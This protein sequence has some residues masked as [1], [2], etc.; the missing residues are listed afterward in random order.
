MESSSNAF[1]A[2][3]LNNFQGE[4]GCKKKKKKKEEEE[5]STSRI[6]NY[7]TLPLRHQPSAAQLSRRRRRRKR[8]LPVRG[9]DHRLWDR[10]A[11]RQLQYQLE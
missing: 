2:F 10:Q 9:L 4:F 6:L 5:E 8:L 3:N 7:L 11:G 1:N